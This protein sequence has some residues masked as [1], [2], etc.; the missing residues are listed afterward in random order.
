ML[1]EVRGEVDLL[2]APATRTALRAALDSPDLL[3]LVVDLSKVDFL[4]AAG[5]TVLVELRDLARVRAVDLR[6]VATTRAVL[7]PLEVTGLRD[8]FR[9]HVDTSGP[10]APHVVT[11]P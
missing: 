7:R 6:L 8:T 1:A 5:L 11:S 3:V 4:A 2:S 10:L 9:L